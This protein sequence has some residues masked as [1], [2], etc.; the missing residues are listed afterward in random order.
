MRNESVTSLLHI[1][2]LKL[3]TRFAEL[4]DINLAPQ[5]PVMGSFS[6]LQF[7]PLFNQVTLFLPIHY[8]AV[9]RATFHVYKTRK[10]CSFYHQLV[11]CQS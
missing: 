11:K 2:R 5:S 3:K 1:I 7:D 8:S 10:S 9:I 4:P 6:K